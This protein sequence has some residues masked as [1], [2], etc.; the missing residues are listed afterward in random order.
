M[1][2]DVVQRLS[3]YVHTLCIV[4]LLYLCDPLI[5][6]CE[7]VDYCGTAVK[8]VGTVTQDRCNGIRRI[9]FYGC[10]RSIPLARSVL[11]MRSSNCRCT[12]AAIS[13]ASSEDKLAYPTTSTNHYRVYSYAAGHFSEDQDKYNQTADSTAFFKSLSRKVTRALSNHAL[14]A[15]L[16]FL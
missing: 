11:C 9:F 4:L 12:R 2:L 7:V 10:M 16:M 14:L 6:T 8:V 1:V 13:Y 5:R 15:M 3:S